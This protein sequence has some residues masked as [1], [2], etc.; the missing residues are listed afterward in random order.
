MNAIK[1]MANAV[2]T[3]TTAFAVAVTTMPVFAMANTDPAAVAAEK[4]NAL[5]V[6]VAAVGGAILGITL[7]VVGFFVI[8]RMANRA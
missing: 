6:G 4:I 2:N 5:Q 3:K 8:K 7:S 1:K